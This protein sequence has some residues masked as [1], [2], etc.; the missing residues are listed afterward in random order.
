MKDKDGKKSK[1]KMTDDL[2]KFCDGVNDSRWYC[3]VIILNTI[4]SDALQPDGL[5]SE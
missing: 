2:G 4:P 5:T 3:L 1:L